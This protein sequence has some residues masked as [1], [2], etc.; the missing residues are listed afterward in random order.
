MKMRKMLPRLTFA[1]LAS[2]L[3]IWSLA[4]AE[5]DKP[6]PTGP[7]V[8]IDSS[9][10]EHKVKGWTFTA[11]TR[12][13]SWLAPAAPAKE[14]P[15]KEPA[16]EDPK[17]KAPVKAPGRARPTTG[18]EALEFREENSTLWLEGI[19][20]L[21]P[22]DHLRAIDYDD[23]D[24]VS[25]RV[26][27][28]DKADTDE[29]LKGTTKFKEINKLAIEAEVD[30]GE[31]GV[32]Q[33]KFLGGVPKGIRGVRFEAPKAAAA[34]AAGRTAQV[35]ADDKNQKTPHKVVELQALY[36]L[37]DGSERLLPTLLFKKTLKLD[38]GTIQ[39]I[40]VHKERDPDGTP[41]TVTLKDGSELTLVLLKSATVDGKTMA[42][43]G[44]LGRVAAGYKL[45]PLQA[46]TDV[47]FEDAKGSDPKPQ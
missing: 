6:A 41:C 12:R 38:V 19:V 16:K 13:L 46:I 36:Q 32:A 14:N 26:A 40:H 43:E 47:R 22:L 27:T 39:K 5:G 7:I 31:L 25:V 8:I 9:G 21:V 11:G 35:T 3:W 10:K 45:F 29:V 28:S 2:G 1:V 15:E 42:L 4:A 30:K 17:G 44:L 24:N 18:P 20:T 34:L 23:K 37:P 33:L